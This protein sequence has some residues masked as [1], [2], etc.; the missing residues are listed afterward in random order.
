MKNILITILL[1]MSLTIYSQSG[2]KL[3]NEQYMQISEKLRKYY[4]E[5]EK[6]SPKAVRE[7]KFND[8]VNEVNP[9]LSTS[10]R[11]KAFQIV[12]AYI[13]A[14][15]GEK[16][17][18]RL[19]KEQKNQLENLLK[20]TRQ[21]K[22]MGIKALNGKLTE[23]RNMSYTEYKNYVTDNGAIPLPE[24]DIRKSYN[25][26]HA[27]D[28]KKV[29]EVPVTNKMDQFKAIDVLQNPKNYSYEEFKSAIL[30]LKPNTSEEDIKKAWDS[31]K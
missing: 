2:T 15:Q 21:K 30:F 10:D 22:E 18:F 16:I 24:N 7:A 25:Q 4:D 26:M 31:S 29:K 3:S 28:E 9:N 5:Y 14:S 6:P 8:Y 13:R 23:I 1:C 11:K 19:E 20:E 12:D 17:D 27:S